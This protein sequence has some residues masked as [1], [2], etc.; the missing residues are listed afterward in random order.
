MLMGLLLKPK[1]KPKPK[2]KPRAKSAGRN[3]QLED[4]AG[5]QVMSLRDHC[6]FA[7]QSGDPGSSSTE[8]APEP[9]D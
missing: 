9:P 1:S 2:L 7:A 6:L 3:R 8:P 5:E 4:N